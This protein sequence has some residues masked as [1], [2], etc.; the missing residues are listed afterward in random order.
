L[1]DAS[2]SLARRLFTH[3]FTRNAERIFLVFKSAGLCVFK[4]EA[5]NGGIELAARNHATL[6]AQNNMKGTPPPLNSNDLFGTSL[7]RRAASLF[8]S[9]PRRNEK[10]GG[11]LLTGGTPLSEKEAARRRT[12]TSLAHLA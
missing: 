6:K 9:F 12:G 1:L 8:P 4:H 7:I 10:R 2:L 11:T 5:S 3:N